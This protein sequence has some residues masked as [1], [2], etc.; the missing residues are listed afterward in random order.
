MKT[1]ILATTGA[2]SFTETEYICPDVFEYGIIVKNIMTGICTSDI[3]MM[4]G[5]F[6]PLPLYMQG[7]EGLGQVMSVG[8]GVRDKNIK[9]GDYVATRGEPAYADC[10]PVR[11]GEYVLVP[12]AH[13]RYIVEPVACGINVIQSD[14]VEI[15]KRIIKNKDSK[16]LLLGSGFLAY[17]AYVTLRLNNI[18]CQIDVVGS[19]NKEVWDKENVTL[20]S[21]PNSGYDV[22]VVLKE[23]DYLEDSNIIN[24]NGLIIDA[25][26]RA[27]TKKESENLLWKAIT[28]TRP[29]PRK[30]V[31]HEYMLDAVKWISNGE[32]NVDSFWSK[33]YNR[34]TEWQNAFADGVNRPAGYSRGYIK[35]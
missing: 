11:E 30:S 2:G 18:Q 6:G 26:G 27:V 5:Q 17:V 24:D 10:Y 16:I 32:I 19:S 7:H 14:I 8:D 4:M 23:T 20:Y 12:E 15:D 22:I 9:I 21:K 1:R 29:S 13:P 3:A 25:V 34:D 28:T 31:F 33:C 35:W